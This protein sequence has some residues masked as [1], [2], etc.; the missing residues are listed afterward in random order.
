MN[1]NVQ[2]VLGGLVSKFTEPQRLQAYLDL[3]RQGDGSSVEVLCDNINYLGHLRNAIICR[4]EWTRWEPQR[5]EAETLLDCL[6]MAVRQ[7]YA[8]ESSNV[9]P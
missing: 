3:L 8:T 6:Q 2:R 4:G 7:R 1:A 9:G 5:Y